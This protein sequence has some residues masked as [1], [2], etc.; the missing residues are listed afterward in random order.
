MRVVPAV[1][2]LG[3]FAACGRFG[4]EGG[5]GVAKPDA[6]PAFDSDPTIDS[7]IGLGDYT[8]TQSTTGYT[9][10]A[11]AMPVP[12]FVGG[13]DDEA[14]SLPLPFTFT[15]YGITYATVSVAVNGYLTF[16][17]PPTGTDNFDNDCAIDA[18]PPDA[19]IAVFW[20]DL[21]ASKMYTPYGSI[22]YAELG[23]AP[24]RRVEIEWRDLDAFYSTGGGNNNFTQLLRTTQKVVLHETGVIDLHYGPRTPP[25]RNQDCGIDRHLGCSA[26][27]GLEAPSSTSSKMIQCGT[28]D[29]PLAGYTPL[30]E[31]RLITFTPQ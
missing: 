8:V 2:A 24:D 31:G 10:L 29:G 19:L 5:D 18:T 28:K 1:V 12:G 23:V 27:V 15:F 20:D 11:A 30:D 22:G 26:T 13:A 14:Y 6:P 4:F 7:P 16:G 21:F 9:P 17:V 25:T 3:T